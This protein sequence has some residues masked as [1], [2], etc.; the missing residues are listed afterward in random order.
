M[1]SQ[2]MK[3]MAALT[4]LMSPPTARAVGIERLGGLPSTGE[5]S[6]SRPATAFQNLLCQHVIKAKL[7]AA[8]MW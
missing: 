7:G 6:P 4:S 5:A 1:S 8:M 2:D 3:S